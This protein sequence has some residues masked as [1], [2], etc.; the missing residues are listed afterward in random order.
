[1]LLKNHYLTRKGNVL[2]GYLFNTHVESL[3]LPPS[4]TVNLS[5]MCMA[6]VKKA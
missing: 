1:M 5:T 3:L 2:S 4:I 6:G